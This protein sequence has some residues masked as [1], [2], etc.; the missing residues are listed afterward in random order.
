MKFAKPTALIFSALLAACPLYASER[1]ELFDV[2]ASTGQLVGQIDTP[3][4]YATP[5]GT[6]DIML[7]KDFIYGVKKIEVSKSVF[8]DDNGRVVMSMTSDS[9]RKIIAQIA[10]MGFR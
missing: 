6:I 10:R 4:P 1:T 2:F 5:E 7:A 3:P 9:I 8:S